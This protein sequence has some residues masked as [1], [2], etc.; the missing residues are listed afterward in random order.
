[1]TR[2]ERKTLLEF[3]AGQLNLVLVVIDARAV[4]VEDGRV[5]G[6][7]LERTVEL[8]QRLVVHAVAAQRDAGDHVHVPV[9]GGAGEQVGDAVARRLLFAARE[10]HVDAI[11]IRLRRRGIELERLIEGAPRVHHVNLSAESVAHIL[12]LGDAEAAPSRGKLRILRGDAGEERV[13][14]VEIGAAS[15]CAP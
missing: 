7:E 4:V 9:V 6:I 11:E 13:G 5:G 2:L 3:V 8:E 14:L 15:R 1:M 10:Q 12:Q